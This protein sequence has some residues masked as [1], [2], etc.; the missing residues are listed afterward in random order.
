[1]KLGGNRGGEIEGSERLEWKVFDHNIYPGFYF[2]LGAGEA[3]SVPPLPTKPFPQPCNR[4]C[5][6][7][8][9]CVFSIYLIVYPLFTGAPKN[10]IDS[11]CH[12]FNDH[13][14]KV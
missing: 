2:F 5:V 11:S 13:P 14:L 9:M 6:W 1:M 8:W 7:G 3:N 10:I 12:K 4:H